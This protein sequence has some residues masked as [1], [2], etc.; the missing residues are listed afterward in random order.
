MPL[1]VNN[2]F[3]AIGSARL[4]FLSLG[5]MRIRDKRRNAKQALTGRGKE[6]DG[7]TGEEYLRASAAIEHT[8]IPGQA[9]NDSRSIFS[10]G[11]SVGEVDSE[12]AFFSGV[13]CE[14]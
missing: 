6:Q 10:I 11:P 8:R 1:S 12:N 4:L 14:K 2:K 13:L 7:K 9:G 5:F 3:L